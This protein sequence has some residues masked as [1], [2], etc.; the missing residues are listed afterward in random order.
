MNKADSLMRRVRDL[1]MGS[2]AVTDHGTL[3]GLHEMRMAAQKAGV[4]LI[5]GLEA[6]VVPD[7]EKCRGAEWSSRGNSR[8]LIL[9]AKDLAGW[10]NLVTL[11]SKANSEGFYSQPRIDH[12]ML[13]QHREG[14][15]C[16]SA[17]LGSEMAAAWR[18]GKGMGVTAD[19][20]RQIFGENYF[21]E[22]Q[23]NGEPEQIPYDRALEALGREMGIRCVATNDSHYLLKEDSFLQ[24]VNFCLGMKKQL[25]DPV[26]HGPGK[27]HKFV[28]EQYSIETPEE[29]CASFRRELGSDAACHMA[30]EIGTMCKVEWE[31]ARVF[32]PRIGTRDLSAEAWEGLGREFPDGIPPEYEERLGHELQVILEMG[33]ESYFLVVQDYIRGARGL[34]IRIGPARG[35]GAG[36]LVSYA[37]EITSVDPIRWE[38]P[39]E[40][41]LNPHRVSLPD[42]D[43]DFQQSRRDEVI[44][45]CLERHGEGT[46]AHVGTQSLFKARGLIRDV[47]RVLGFDAARQNDFARAIPD[48]DRGGQGA[49]RVTLSK[50]VEKYDD[51]RPKAH[52]CHLDPFFKKKYESDPD[53]Q[54][55]CDI[56]ERME[57]LRRHS[58]IHASGVIIHDS[59]LVDKVPLKRPN[60]RTGCPITEWDMHELE[61]LGYVKYDFLGLAVLDVIEIAVRAIREKLHD[62][63]FDVLDLDLDDQDVF[64]DVFH[65][66]RSYGIFQFEQ[67]GMRDFAKGFRPVS[68]EDLSSI[69]A[70]YRPGPLDCGMVEQIL[71]IRSGKDRPS[72]WMAKRP[73]SDVLRKTDGVLVYQEQV[74]EVT[75]RLC[76]FSLAEADLMRRA[77][78]K[79]KP[80]EMEALESKFLEGA[81]SNGH[82][83]ELA[84]QAWDGIKTFADYA[85][86]RS[87]SVS[88]A[89]IAY[90]TAWLKHHHPAEFFA[91]M[92]TVK[93]SSME[94]IQ[95][96]VDAAREEGL[97][98]LP[99]DV[100]LSGVEFEAR[101]RTILF[102]LGAIKGFGDTASSALLDARGRGPF[103]G[104]YDFCKRV[105]LGKCRA[106]NVLQLV[107]AGAFDSLGHDRAQLEKGHE[108]AMRKSQAV[109]KDRRSGQTSLLPLFEVE[110]EKLDLPPGDLQ[111][112]QILLNEREVLGVYLSGHPLDRYKAVTDGVVTHEAADIEDLEVGTEIVLGG[113][114]TRTQTKEVGRGTMC[115]VTFGD[116]SGSID[117]VVWPAVFKNIQILLVEGKALMARV[118]VDEYKD[119]KNVI[120]LGITDMEAELGN[121]REV[122]IHLTRRGDVGRVA[123]VAHDHKGGPTWL[124][125]QV[126][127]AWLRPFKISNPEGMERRL[128]GLEGVRISM[129]R[130]GAT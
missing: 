81:M 56:A 125:I 108:L 7:V 50:T 35:S 59:S 5:P 26:G 112:D 88:Y 67:K 79:K 120:V 75:R 99:P 25:S 11:M 110:D 61:E 14:L 109:Q 84:R 28:P 19:L 18:A 97:R 43:T 111:E 44:A 66:G 119:R 48:E 94:K 13:R 42:I 90:Q 93:S 69:L 49:H 116:R 41:F 47:A 89:L 37:L 33:Y 23:L 30:A 76:G 64:R 57:S 73:I 20:H 60:E 107:H 115:F 80:K 92:M 21:L 101:D 17:C 15:I 91:A 70:L 96:L 36:S 105:H 2:V 51:G 53:F 46:V 127:D 72:G 126:G 4:N 16:L 3:S 1:G 85:F 39:F 45:W 40:R 9:L 78:G 27:R 113:F 98:V 130:Q 34:G 104:I 54:R 86:N 102:G 12:R 83:E 95:E 38:L 100:N 87:H 117:G 128:R 82:D 24:D 68:I 31:T 103:K 124:R 63:S 121:V 29:I 129:I 52:Y 122:V 10:R 32:I 77:I 74:L 6:Y 118:Q 65:S 55:A 106:N 58:S 71:A 123:E 62:E 22:L 114:L 8:H